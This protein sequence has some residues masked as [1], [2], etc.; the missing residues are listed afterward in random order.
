MGHRI[1]L[2]LYKQIRLMI[3]GTLTSVGELLY[4]LQQGEEEPWMGVCQL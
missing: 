1:G 3:G 2:E 4:L